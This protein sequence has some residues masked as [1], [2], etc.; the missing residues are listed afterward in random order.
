MKII[1]KDIEEGVLSL[2]GFSSR[3]GA[4]IYGKE[5]LLSYLYTQNAYY[6]LFLS[7]DCSENTRKFWLDKTCLPGV[8]LYVFESVTKFGLAKRLGKYELSVVATDNANILEGIRKLLK[9]NLCL[10]I[11]DR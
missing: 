1:K 6:M 5:K 11:S 4:L 7:S 3:M 9:E 10:D 8:E 2:L